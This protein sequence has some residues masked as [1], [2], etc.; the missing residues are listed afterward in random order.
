MGLQAQA[1]WFAAATTFISSMG[2]YVVSVFKVCRLL[3]SYVK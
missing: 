3:N 1:L 2:S